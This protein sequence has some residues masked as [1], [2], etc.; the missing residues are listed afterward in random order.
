MTIKINE[1]WADTKVETL[2]DATAEEIQVIEKIQ[3]DELAVK[4]AQTAKEAA[5]ASA[6]EK[7]AALGLTA[8]ELAAIK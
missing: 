4:E 3:S 5:K 6:F 8:E 2:R 1:V 7:L